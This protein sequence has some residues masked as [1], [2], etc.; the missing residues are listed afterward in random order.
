MCRYDARLTNQGKEQALKASKLVGR[1]QPCPEVVLVSPLT[2]AL[3]TCALAF[4]D[5]DIP[6][7]VEPLLRERIVLSSEVGRSPSFLREE[8]PGFDFSRL[9]DDVWWHTERPD[10]LS[11][12][13]KEP[14]VV[15]RER[16]AELRRYLKHRPEGCVAL[17]THWGVVHSL[18]GMA[19]DSAELKTR[20]IVL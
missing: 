15:Y 7:E 6:V 16:L 4:G 13:C 10:D 14:D 17:V 3:E 20:N 5:L 11:L 1:L 18:T 9:Q 12:V 19:L 2:R 8:F